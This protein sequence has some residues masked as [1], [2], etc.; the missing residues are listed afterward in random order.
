MALT[1]VQSEMAGAGQVIQVVQATTTGTVTTSGSTYTSS[2]LTASITPKFSTSKVLV[3]V[4]G[5]DFDNSTAGYVVIGTIYRNSTNLGGGSNLS[6]TTCY[7]QLTRSIFPVI[8]QYLDSPATTSSTTYTMYF[9]SGG[10]NVVKYN[11]Q[12]GMG[13]ITLMEI[14]A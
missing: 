12:N 2:G 13:V 10:S 8:L 6:L 4:T 7:S 5:G 1:K 3:T 11:T 9:Y 14:A